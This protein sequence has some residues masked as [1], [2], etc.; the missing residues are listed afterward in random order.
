MFFTCSSAIHCFEWLVVAVSSWY[1][2][3][4][5]LDFSKDIRRKARWPTYGAVDFATLFD[6]E[7][8]VSQL[9]AVLN[10][11]FNFGCSGSTAFIHFTSGPTDSSTNF[12]LDQNSSISATVAAG[13][14]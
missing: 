8:I 14:D 7:R 3:R 13:N 1:R 12:R 4:E 9:A 2:V 10:K 5:E 11:L 6:T